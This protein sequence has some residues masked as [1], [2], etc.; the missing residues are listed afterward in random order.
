MA[1]QRTLLLCLALFFRF[2]LLSQ[3]DSAMLRPEQRMPDGVYLTYNDFRYSRPILKEQIVS[4]IDKDQQEFLGKVMWEERFSFKRNDSV[5]VCDSRTAWGFMQNNTLYVFYRDDF[6]RVPVFGSISY[7]VANVTIL[8]SGFYDARFGTSSG[9]VA[10]REIR[11][12]LMDFYDGQVQE[13]NTGNFEPLVSRDKELYKEYKKLSRRAQRDEM[14]R[15][16][17]KYNERNPVYFL[18]SD[19]H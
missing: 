4:D 17:R 14:Y 8:N 6:Y 2:A 7:L 5:I 1:T 18:R 12:F 15:F 10:S 3:S 16:V 19:A 11:E 13:L 9:A